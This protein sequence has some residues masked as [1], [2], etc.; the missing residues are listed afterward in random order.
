VHFHFLDALSVYPWLSWCYGAKQVFFT[1]HS[2]HSEGYTLRPASP[3][4]RF[5]AYSINWH[6]TAM[7]CPSD[8]SRRVSAAAGILPEP[9]IHRIY[10]GVSLPTLEDTIVRGKRFR[11]TYGIPDEAPVIVQISWLIPEKGIEDLLRAA[12][13]VLSRYSEARFII[14]GDG[15]DRAKFQAMAKADGIERSILWT[16]FLESPTE[17]GLFDAAD[18]ICQ[19]SRW[20]EAFGY[21]I[22]EGMSFAK[23]VVAT[24]VG[25]IPEVIRHEE[26]GLLSPRRDPQTAA[27][28]ICRLLGDAA[29]RRKFGEAGR[30]RIKQKFNVVDR[31]REMLCYYDFSCGDIDVR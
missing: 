24:R 31:V 18:I 27:E 22:A 10:N 17:S 11:R 29:L 2:S 8:Y 23:P 12:K 21:V 4:K 28:N 26:T 6:L 25:G 19:L 7:F 3:L 15:R 5:T 9:R 14:V 16:G 13:I 30:V 1:N 20:E